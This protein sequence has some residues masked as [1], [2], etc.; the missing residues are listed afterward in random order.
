[1]SLQLAKYVLDVG[2][3]ALYTGSPAKYWA[4]GHLATVSFVDILVKGFGDP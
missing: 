2:Q 3:V 1:M 4:L